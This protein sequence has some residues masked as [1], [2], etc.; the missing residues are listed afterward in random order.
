MQYDWPGLKLLHFTWQHK[1]MFSLHSSGRFLLN[2]L[3]IAVS[4]WLL[5]PTTLLF[6]IGLFAS[7]AG[8][9]HDLQLNGAWALIT[10][11]LLLPGAGLGAVWWLTFAFPFIKSVRSV[12][13]VIYVGLFVGAAFAILVFA[14]SHPR[15]ASEMTTIAGAKRLLLGTSSFG[16]GPFLASILLI[17]GIWVRQRCA[18]KGQNP[19]LS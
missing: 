10:V 11:V 5:L 19:P 9:F 18:E 1:L 6:G 3:V 16:G 8:T 17:A 15:L 2:A 14:T 12:P 7:I 13:R 4:L